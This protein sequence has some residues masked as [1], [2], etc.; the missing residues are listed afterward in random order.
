[1]DAALG[2]DGGEAASEHVGA[3]RRNGIGGQDAKIEVACDEGEEAAE[4]GGAGG[5]ECLL[6]TGLGERP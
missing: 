6:E 5:A 3:F 1:M 4:L 2:E